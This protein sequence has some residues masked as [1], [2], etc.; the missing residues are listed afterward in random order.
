MDKKKNPLICNDFVIT[1]SSTKLT[2]PDES[3]LNF[4]K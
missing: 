2:F 1:N 4:V 3:K